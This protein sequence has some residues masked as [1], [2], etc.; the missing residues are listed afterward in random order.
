MYGRVQSSA[1]R[2]SVIVPPQ[3]TRPID[4]VLV[5]A[6]ESATLTCQVYG[7]PTPSVAWYK[8]TLSITNISIMATNVEFCATALFH[9]LKFYI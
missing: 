6:G 9:R 4:D 2:L 7:D 5:E 8:G 1:V 3:I